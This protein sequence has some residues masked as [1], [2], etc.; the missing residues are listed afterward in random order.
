MGI[1]RR[2]DSRWGNAL[3]VTG[4][5]LFLSHVLA[6]GQQHKGCHIHWLHG[7][8]HQKHLPFFSNSSSPHASSQDAPKDYYIIPS[9][10]GRGEA[11]GRR[12]QGEN[13]FLLAAKTGLWHLGEM[14]D[15]K[16]VSS[17]SPR[18]SVPPLGAVHA[19]GAVIPSGDEHPGLPA[20]GVAGL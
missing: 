10:W 11:D 19:S 4:L 14:E 5:T 18:C 16:G 12:R 3:R 8:S 6:M 9:S 2:Q 20:A 7:S 15:R 17:P 1:F 13:S